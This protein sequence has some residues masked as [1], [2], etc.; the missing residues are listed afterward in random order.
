M[1]CVRIQGTRSKKVAQFP[2]FHNNSLPTCSTFAGCTSADCSRA[3][4]GLLSKPIELSGTTKHDVPKIVLPP[5]RPPSNR[6][7]RSESSTGTPLGELVDKKDLG[8]LHSSIGYKM[9]GKPR[10][11]S[12][13]DGSG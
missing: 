6:D 3:N 4:G 10:R 12:I 11:R 13:G 1:V 8:E 9:D 5:P 2:A 7:S